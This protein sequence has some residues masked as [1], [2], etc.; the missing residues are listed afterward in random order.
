MNFEIYKTFSTT[1][2]LK[3]IG[4]IKTVLNGCVTE[5]CLNEHAL[6]YL[7]FG[8]GAATFSSCSCLGESVVLNKMGYSSYLDDKNQLI[9]RTG[10]TDL[11]SPFLMGLEND[12]QPSKL[13]EINSPRG[14]MLNQLFNT[15]GEG[16]LA[17][18][19]TGCLLFENLQSSYLIKPPIFNEP[20]NDNVVKYWAKTDEHTQCY[21]HLFGVVIKEQGK[22]TFSSEIL[23]KAFYVNPLEINQNEILSHTH[24]VLIKETLPFQTLKNDFRF[25]ENNAPTSIMGIRH[26][27]THSIVKSGL[28]ALFDISQITE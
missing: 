23:Q 8:L 12:C 3:I 16:L 7:K 24:A 19:F 28:L 2:T 18:A 10:T 25:Y 11:K 5:A 4:N 27:F 26:V 14:I 20:I 21:T 13:L 17:Y 1:S 9:I 6:N 22:K 15:L